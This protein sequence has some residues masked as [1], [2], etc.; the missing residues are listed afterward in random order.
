MPSIL[1][2]PSWT[3][4]VIEL[5]VSS[6]SDSQ[7]EVRTKAGEVLSGLLHGAFIGKEKKEEL[8]VR[9]NKGYS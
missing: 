3:S 4:Q 1:S 5:V 6:L 9:A 7:V 2:S 8:R